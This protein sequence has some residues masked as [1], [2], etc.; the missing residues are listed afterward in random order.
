MKNAF[1]LILI[2]CVFTA[3]DKSSDETGEKKTV[4]IQLIRN[5]TIK[6]EY[7]GKTFLTDPMLSPKESFM[8]FVEPNVNK[9]PTVDLPMSNQEILNGVHAVLVTHAHPDHFDPVAIQQINKDLPLFYQPFDEKTITESAFKNARKVETAINWE[10]INII[11]TGGKHGK[12]EV[13]QVMGEV[14]G[15]VLKAENYPTVYLIGDCIWDDEIKNNIAKYNPDIIITHSGGA[16]FQG[17]SQILMDAEETI[18]VVESTN[19]AKVIAIHMESLDHC[20][21]TR[22]Q[23]RELANS[24]NISKDR[25][26]IPEDGKIIEL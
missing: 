1:L 15:F 5:A 26:I 6:I 17:N 3:C 7:A 24:K 13:L 19:S 21:V 2:F 10:G 20:P 14:S 4:K 18:K 16:L 23:L 22:N 25:L 8:S 9:N 11:R 12:G